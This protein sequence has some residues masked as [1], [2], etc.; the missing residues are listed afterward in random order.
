MSE[1][2]KILIVEDE[3]DILQ[4]FAVRIEVNGYDVVTAVDGEEALEKVN[5][6]NPDLILL[7]LMIPKIDGYE[8]C[9][10]L[11]FDDETKNIPI[12]ILS[13]LNEAVDKQKALDAGVDAYFVKPFDLEE[14]VQKIKEL[15]V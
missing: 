1:P 10:T 8:V 6:E 14:L 3:V 7:D 15:I 2:K 13:A 12:I 11:K 4:L 5:S 9:R